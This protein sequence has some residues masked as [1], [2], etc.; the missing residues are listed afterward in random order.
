MHATSFP[1][2]APLKKHAAAGAIA[3]FFTSV[4]TA[5]TLHVMHHS[6]TAQLAHGAIHLE[7]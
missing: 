2:Q 1:P 3:I 4:P 7:K 6:T 5:V